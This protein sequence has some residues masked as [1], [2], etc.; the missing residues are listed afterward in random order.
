MKTRFVI[1][2]VLLNLAAL[3]AG[4]LYF[5]QSA[6]QEVAQT[7]QSAQAELA[8]WQAKAAAAEQQAEPTVIYKTN[9]LTWNQL[10]STDY[11]QYIA[12]LRSVACP[13]ST[14][15][16][17]IMTDVMRLYAQRLGQYYRNGRDFKF[18][19]TDEKRKLKQPQIEEREKQLALINKE[20]P[21]VLR[22]LLGINYE[23]EINKY[24]VDTDED[25]RRLGFLSDDK[26]SQL[27]SLRD[28]YEGQRERVMYLVENGQ[29]SQADMD[30]LRQIDQDQDAA[31]STLLTPDEKENYELSESSTAD[32]LRKQLVGFNPTE[33][34]F[35]E[36]FRRQQAIDSTYAYADP[37]DESVRAAKESAEQAM[38]T[39]FKTTLTP[40]R[41]AQLDKSQ[42]PEYQ[43]LCVLS[44]QYDLPQGTSEALLDMQQSAETQKQQL[45]A[46]KDM[47]SDQIEVALKSIQAETEKEARAALGDEAFTQYSQSAKWMQ[48]LGTN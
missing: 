4:Y 8:V 34:E 12:N 35:R 33:D 15:K 7:Q 14:I 2:L 41:V 20:L 40:D 17:I 22:E 9:S 48:N 10:E 19:E 30:K 11:R 37:N 45:L 38:M 5:S 16:D 13:E 43:N 44:E 31:L 29:P 24:F 18:W 46:N 27:L 3:G 39:D 25:T 21:A 6:K 36:M 23:R 28:Q 32:S 47:S 42:N 1:I 26:R